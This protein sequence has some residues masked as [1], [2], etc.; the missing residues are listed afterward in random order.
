MYTFFS[1]GGGTLN[2]PGINQGVEAPTPPLPPHYQAEYKKNPSLQNI[3][4]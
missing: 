4:I 3:N 1:W 2:S